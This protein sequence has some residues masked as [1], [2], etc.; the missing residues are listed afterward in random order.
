LPSI[1]LPIRIVCAIW[2]FL[3]LEV[4]V[5]LVSPINTA[6]STVL[7]ALHVVKIVHPLPDPGLLRIVVANRD[8]LAQMVIAWRVVK[9]RF[10]RVRVGVVHLA[11]T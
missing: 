1:Q 10:A 2:A 4:F 9:M 3:D 6:R 8:S 7:A 5:L 11:P